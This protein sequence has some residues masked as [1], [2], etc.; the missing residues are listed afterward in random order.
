VTVA[1]VLP[2]DIGK[3]RKRASE[4]DKARAGR[5]AIRTWAKHVE[6]L[7][8]DGVLRSVDT[9]V[10]AALMN[11]PSATLYGYSFPKQKTLAE[12]LNLS[13]R[14]V[15]R[16]IER[17]KRVRA[18][19]IKQRGKKHSSKYWFCIAG[20]LVISDEAVRFSSD[21]DGH[22]SPLS[23]A[24]TGPSSSDTDGHP[25]PLSVA[26]NGPEESCYLFE[27]HNQES[28]P[29]PPTSSAPVEPPSG[30]PSE[31]HMLSGEVLGPE[32]DL[33]F[34][35]FWKAIRT[36]PGNAGAALAAWRKLSINDRR[37]IGHL[38]G[39]HGI[40]LDGIWAC[41]WLKDRRWEA[42]R[43]NSRSSW[44]EALDE[45]KAF[46]RRRPSDLKPYS[47]EWNAERNRKV[48]A[49]EPV[50]LMDA[51]ARDGRGWTIIEADE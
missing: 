23:V 37:A 43:L 34:D 32:G 5:I 3:S 31:N 22:P 14:T 38:I 9:R 10:A 16:S 35:D 11:Y 18:L 28:P 27:S 47:A 15:R 6:Q 25:N 41:T 36:Q 50:K 51:W 46:N 7:T 40:E 8:R 42:A 26:M 45:L 17:M 48:A 21:T 24:R 44:T 39:P 29:K 49:G 12:A 19:H 2:F 4:S 20:E 1:D 13:K 30:Q 33:T